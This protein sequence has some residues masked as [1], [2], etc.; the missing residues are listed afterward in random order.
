MATAKSTAGAAAKAKPAPKAAAPKAA[1]P[2]AVDTS[3]LEAKV[4]ALE[5]AVAGLQKELAEAKSA[6]PAASSSAKCC[7]D[8][9]V[10][11]AALEKT[12]GHLEWLRKG[13][14]VRR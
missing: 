1:A 9:D 14:K 11:L 13:G 2:K 8:C 3:A 4:A 7:E 12:V 5:S 10:R 6:K